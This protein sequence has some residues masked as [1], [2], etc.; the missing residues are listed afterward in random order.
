MMEEEISFTEQLELEELE[1]KKKEGAL[2]KTDED[3]TVYDWDEEK[4]AWFPKIDEDFIAKYQMSYGANEEE[5]GTNITNDQDKYKEYWENYHKQQQQNE[6]ESNAEGVDINSEEYYKKY[7]EYYQ[8]YYAQ[9]Y[10]Q[11]QQQSTGQQE[12]EGAKCEGEKKGKKRKGSKFIVQKPAEEPQWFDV[13]DEKN[14]NVYVSGLPLDITEEEFKELM[15]KCGMI[16]FDPQRKALKL[17]LY[18]DENGQPKGD[19][20]CCY[21]KVESVE[22]ALKILD[23]YDIR[24]HKI[25]VERAKF[26]MKGNFDPSKKRKKLTNKE[27]KRLKEKQQKLFDWRPERP[28]D[29]RLKCEKVVIL[30]NMFSPKEFD[31]DPVL[32]NELRDDVRQESSKFGDVKNVKI[33]DNHPEGVMSVSFKEPEQADACIAAMNGRWFAKRR[34]SAESWDG[35]TKYEIQESEAE[36]DERLKKWEQY[37]ETDKEKQVDVPDQSPTNTSF[38]EATGASGVCNTETETGVSPATVCQTTQAN[39][40]TS[41]AQ[42]C[43]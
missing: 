1:R 6:S 29:A 40:T 12:E 11:Q 20:R 8:N 22:L 33:Y 23:G 19:G 27:K 41:G 18:T 36:R 31:V 24:G 39:D 25:H 7:T 16:M 38:V 35:K 32:I 34:I 10:A 9:Y 37:L 5:G 17:K 15:N 4:R 42:G 30:K 28:I 21:I 3:G 26:T 14:T 43:Q 2:T 13:Q